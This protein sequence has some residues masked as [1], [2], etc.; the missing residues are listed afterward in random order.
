MDM[1]FAWRLF[2][3]VAAVTVF[4][5]VKDTDA[6]AKIHHVNFTVEEFIKRELSPFPLDTRQTIH[7]NELK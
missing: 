7:C 3:R 4:P 6:F 5:F 2:L 1:T